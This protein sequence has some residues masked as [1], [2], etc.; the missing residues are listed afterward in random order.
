MLGGSPP[1]PEER[2]A[3]K[4]PVSIPDILTCHQ[5]VSSNEIFLAATGVTPA[6]A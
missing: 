5:I 6:P 1:E 2:E 4:M 3:C